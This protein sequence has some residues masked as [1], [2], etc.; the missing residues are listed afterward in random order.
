MSETATLAKP[1]VK[2]DRPSPAGVPDREKD[3]VPARPGALT[4]THPLT[5]EVL[6]RDPI[7][8]S[9]S[10]YH[11]PRDLVP[12]GM[13]YQWCRESILGEPDQPNISRLKR[14]GWR[15]VPADRHPEF[16]VRIEGLILM[17]CPEPFVAQSK[18]EER[19]KAQAE[20]YKQSR[21]RNDASKPGLFD[22][23]S[24]AAR[25]ANF[26]RRGRPEASDPSLR[27]VY[28]RNVDIDG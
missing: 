17:E 8:E 10:Q 26:A 5:G 27:P 16:P 14:N 12:D 20:K 2:A 3:R 13:I 25:A 21:P 24:P 7:P 9:D 23:D 4:F 6:T 22:Q 15:E 28:S 19:Q 18:L 1:R 11:I